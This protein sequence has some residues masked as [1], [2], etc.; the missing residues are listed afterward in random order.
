MAILR[1]DDARFRHLSRKVGV[2]LSIAAAGIALALVSVAV[3]QGLFVP[4]TMVFFLTD[5]GRDI[6]EGMAVKLSGFNIGKVRKLALTEQATVKVTLEINDAYMKWVRRDSKAR[7][8]KEGVIG[9]N[10]IEIA[11]GSDKSPR[12]AKDGELAFERE[13]GMGALI[14]D[15]YGEIRPLIHD[16]RSA[17]RSADVLLS[18]LPATRARLDTALGSAQRNFENLE[19]VT[20]TD[21]PAAVRGGREVVESSKKVVDSMSRTWPLSNNIEPLKAGVLPLD[22]YGATPA[23]GAATK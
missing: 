9:D 1:D 7:L 17:V 22:S 8:L 15:L 23:T 4:K 6:A 16:L 5:S 18:D 20:G 19:K 2:F 11:P 13:R 12:L 10:I 14:D 21:L 3:Q